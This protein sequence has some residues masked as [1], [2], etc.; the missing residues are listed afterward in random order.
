MAL[1]LWFLPLVVLA[2]ISEDWVVP[3]NVPLEVFADEALHG[4]A[5]GSPVELDN[6]DDGHIGPVSS[7]GDGAV[8]VDPA[9]ATTSFDVEDV[10]DLCFQVWVNREA[11]P[12]DVILVVIAS[13]QLSQLSPV[14]PCVGDC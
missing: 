1:A 5:A 9:C 12:V 2:V 6:V 13:D 11:S 8:A 14:C 4:D 3:W 10:V 7:I